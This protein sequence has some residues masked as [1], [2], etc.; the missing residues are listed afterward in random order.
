MSQRYPAAHARAS[1]SASCSPLTK[2]FFHQP[3]RCASV[4]KF[5]FLSPHPKASLQAMKVAWE[6]RQR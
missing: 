1:S 3:A 4:S 5:V 6:Q 2:S